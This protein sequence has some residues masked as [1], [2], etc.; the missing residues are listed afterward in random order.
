MS[1]E[2]DSVSI[3]PNHDWTTNVAVSSIESTYPQIGTL[4]SISVLSRNGLGAD[5]GRVTSLLIRGTAGSA[6]VSGGDNVRSAFGLKSD[7]F[8]V[9]APFVLN[10]PIVGM[11]ST[12]SGNG[13]WLVA[14]DGGLFSFG[15]A[16]FFGSTGSMPLN[17]PIVGMASTPSGNGYWLVASDEIGRAHV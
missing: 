12:P 5:G 10:K 2:G 6:T 14:S 4:S 3:N 11:A 17:K 9:S 15:D 13:Y 16:H 8:T 7:W 1:D